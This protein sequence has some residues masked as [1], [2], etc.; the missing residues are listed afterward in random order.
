MLDSNMYVIM[1]T[2]C[3]LI[4]RYPVRCHSI[5]AVAVVLFDFFPQL[6]GT[7]YS[8]DEALANIIVLTKV[9]REP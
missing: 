8:S 9:I 3:Q 6:S 4:F 1:Y 5:L 2:F 7:V